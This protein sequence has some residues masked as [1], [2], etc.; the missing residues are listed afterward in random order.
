MN[1]LTIF[2]VLP[3]PRRKLSMLLDTTRIYVI[4]Q[5][6]EMDEAY[7]IRTDVCMYTE[8]PLYYDHPPSIT[9][10][11]SS[12]NRW[13]VYYAVG[14]VVIDHIRTHKRDTPIPD[15]CALREHYCKYLWCH[16]K[17]KFILPF[18]RVAICGNCW[19]SWWVLGTKHLR[20]PISILWSQ[21][22]ARCWPVWGL[23]AVLH[24]ING[25]VII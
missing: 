7:S 16:L 8:E 12:P 15:L 1:C 25:V 10:G 3:W 23:K 13:R 21:C 22:H 9:M 11:S 5:C 4:K 20:P 18:H 19:T 24:G 6:S 14:N 2:L 17:T